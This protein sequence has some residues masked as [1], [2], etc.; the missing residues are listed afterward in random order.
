ME[1]Y[2][3][4]VFEVSFSLL[5]PRYLG[6]E[7]LH[8]VQSLSPSLPTGDTLSMAWGS[9]ELNHGQSLTEVG[10]EILLTGNWG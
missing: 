8:K 3:S 4:F 9:H 1:R 10:V 6:A 2:W 7:F 5:V